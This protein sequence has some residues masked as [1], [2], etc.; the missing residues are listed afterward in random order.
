MLERF[1]VTPWYF[2][3][4]VVIEEGTIPHSHPVLTLNTAN[5]RGFLLGTFVHEQLHWYVSDRD[6][7]ADRIY[8]EVLL[9]RYPEVPVGLPEGAHDEVSTYLHLIVNWLE[10]DALRRL[11]GREEADRL[12]GMFCE[13]GVYRWIY[14][15]VLRDYDELEMAFAACCL[16]PPP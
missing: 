15:M 1:D 14:R 8:E 12:V 16:T 2:T 4:D 3:Q 13:R 6:E 7:I 10:V 9:A 5:H 11:L